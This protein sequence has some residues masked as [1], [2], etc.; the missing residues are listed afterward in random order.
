MAQILAERGL[1]K[2]SKLRFECQ[3]FKCAPGSSNC[4]V[5]RVLYNQPDFTAV[6]SQL[7]TVCEAH[8]FRVVFLPKFHCEL[9]FI[10]QCWGY[11][12]SMESKTDLLDF[13]TQRDNAASALVVRPQTPI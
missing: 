10:G 13:Q 9:N 3:S 8:G 6:K 7:E 4:C 11:A 1:V 2:E 5:R 12:K